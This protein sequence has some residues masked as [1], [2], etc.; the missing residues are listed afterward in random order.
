[1]PTPGLLK[2]ELLIAR[3]GRVVLAIL[4]VASLAAFGG[5]AYVV[6]NPATDRVTVDE[7]KQ[8]VTAS[9]DTRAVAT[10]ESGLWAEGTVL[11]N[12]PV[13][14]DESAPKLTVIGSAARTPGG[15][16]AATQSLELEFAARADNTVFWTERQ[17]LAESEKQTVSATINVSDLRQQLQA[18]QQEVGAAGTVS[19]RVVHTVEYESGR[20][21]GT[22]TTTSAFSLGTGS[23]KLPPTSESQPHRTTKTVTRT[24]APDWQTAGIV[25]AAGLASLAA[26]GWALAVYRRDE[27][28]EVVAERLHRKRYDEWIS[29]GTL[30]AG[31]AERHVEMETLDDLVNVGID[32]DKRTVYD[33]VAGRY[34]V[35]DGETLYTFEEVAPPEAP[36][37]DDTIETLA[38][39][40]ASA[41]DSDD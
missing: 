35:I 5:A 7:N 34:G 15:K 9:L 17:P 2:A 12:K 31:V 33:A 38:E 1:M 22:L 10:G 37:P 25:G 30:P 21:E 41:N 20:Y 40:T 14:L 3:S 6:E 16:L 39:E 13:Y 36:L 27:D 28:P 18:Y 8:T 24:E 32:A 29:R 19:V 11:R 26:F 23:Y 4:L